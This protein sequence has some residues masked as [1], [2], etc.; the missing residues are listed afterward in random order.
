MLVSKGP[1]PEASE[2]VWYHIFGGWSEV[3]DAPAIAT[4]SPGRHPDTIENKEEG[5][6][7]MEYITSV[8][9]EPTEEEIEAWTEQIEANYE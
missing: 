2:T 7:G 9:H 1:E 4:V 5:Y 8:D 6:R 3:F